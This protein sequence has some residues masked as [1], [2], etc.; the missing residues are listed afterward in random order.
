MCQNG[1][2]QAS[3]RYT[4]AEL[5][6]TEVMSL[7]A[8]SLFSGETLTFCKLVNLDKNS[9][10]EYFG[11]NLRRKTVCQFL[12]PLA[13]SHLTTRRVTQNPKCRNM[14]IRPSCVQGVVRRARNYLT[15]RCHVRRPGGGEVLGRG[16]TMLRRRE[17]VEYR[18]ATEMD[19]ESEEARKVDITQLK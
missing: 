7:S 17:R 12:S 8:F 14:C 15:G 9:A 3:A 5:S 13:N 4:I 1:V 16:R 11:I 6:T 19:Y 18:M 10:F 2:Y